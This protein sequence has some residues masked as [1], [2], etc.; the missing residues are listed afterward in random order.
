[1]RKNSSREL[2]KREMRRLRAKEKRHREPRGVS[3]FAL[4]GRWFLF[5]GG[6]ILSLLIAAAYLTPL[7]SISKIEVVGTERVNSADVIRKLQPVI[8]ESLTTISEEQV[9]S[10]LEDFGLID[11]IALES[12][13]PHTL[14]VRIQERQPIA[15]VR[16]SGKDFLYDAAGVKVAE[17]NGDES[18]PKIRGIGN[19]SG[20][21]KFQASIKVILEMPNSLFENLES[22]EFSGSSA[23]LR[24]RNHDFDVIWGDSSEG[25]LKAEVLESILNSLDSEPKLVDVSSPMAPVVRY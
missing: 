23:V 22:F 24:V 20:S 16:T 4:L 6:L 19:P 10:L 17:A 5:G 7:L 14:L 21:E 25:A 2:T 18:L 1:M 8:G 15:I 12:K 13:P 11:T 9:T 3:D